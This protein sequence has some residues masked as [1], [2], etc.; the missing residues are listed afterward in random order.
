MIYILL[1]LAIFSFVIA[2]V[3]CAE[4]SVNSAYYLEF[5][6]RCIKFPSDK[7]N[8]KRMRYYR[9]CYRKTKRRAYISLVFCALLT[10]TLL[11]WAKMT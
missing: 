6:N 10:T 11:L 5:A 1:P 3:F 2:I 4:A 9:M 7:L 8:E